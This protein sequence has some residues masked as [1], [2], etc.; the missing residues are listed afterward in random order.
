MKLN[1]NLRLFLITTLGVIATM[2]VVLG[3]SYRTFDK[4]MKKNFHEKIEFIVRQ[5]ESSAILALAFQDKI[6]LKKLAENV[7]R[8]EVI[9]AIE[10]YGRNNKKLISIGRKNREAFKIEKTIIT[11]S[12]SQEE[13]LTSLP[14]KSIF[15][16]RIVLY[17]TDVPIKK[18]MQLLFLRSL[19]AGI[20]L[21][22][23][24]DLTLYFLVS[25]AITDPLKELV[26]RVRHVQK[27]NLEFLPLEVS[28]PEVKELSQAFGEM[29][30][31]LL[32]SRKALAESY[33]KMLKNKTLAE[34]GKFSLLIAHE[35]K[36]PLG[37]I[38]GSLDILKKENIDPEV[39]KQMLSYIEEEVSRINDLVQNFLTFA[40]PKKLNFEKIN[41]AE[42]LRSL[43]KKLTTDKTKNIHL[44]ITDDLTIIGDY[45]WLERVFINL[46]QN[47]FEVGAKNI[48]IKAEKR[49]GEIR[50]YFED[51]GP[52]IP[53]EKRSEIFKPF[54][55]GKI[56]GGIGLGLAIVDQIVSFHK[57]KIEIGES[58]KGGA[59][60]V[61]KF[62]L[63]S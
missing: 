1:L 62:P 48:W 40:R 51:D 35:I 6:T 14:R 15:L 55:T 63:S 56:K 17:Y 45:Y 50:L 23:L 19:L 32:K 44:L 13:F 34:I 20:L 4:M 3:F 31:S 53:E 47:S 33:E 11:S 60:F 39:K 26:K 54:Y 59:L 21:S 12:L 2:S 24:I 49:E 57:G 22:I 58:Q 41:L 5:L 52:G 37:I 25:K 43:S 46:I 8:E 61:L 10:I 16:G 18:K 7:L 36:N 29:V 30:D 42:L 38:K 28:L 27:G 9:L